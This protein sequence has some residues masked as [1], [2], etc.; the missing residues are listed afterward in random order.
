MA[1][2]GDGTAFLAVDKTILNVVEN[3]EIEAD[4]VSD[5]AKLWRFKINDTNCTL[6]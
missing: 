6:D 4:K 3:I 5:W 1:T 2:Y